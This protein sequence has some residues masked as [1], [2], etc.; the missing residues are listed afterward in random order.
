ME[1][2]V[3]TYVLKR[4]DDEAAPR[5]LSIDYAAALN[6]QQLAAVTAGEIPSVAAAPGVSIAATTTRHSNRLTRIFPN[7]RNMTVN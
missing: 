7:F 1:R 2:D 3:K 6:P 5:K 4:S